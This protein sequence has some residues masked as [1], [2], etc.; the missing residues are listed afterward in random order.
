MS[1]TIQINN[2]GTLT[3]PIGI[4]KRLGL[5]K[6]GAV[7]AEETEQGI[8][9]KPA[10]TYPIEI[11]SEMRVKEFDDQDSALSAYMKKKTKKS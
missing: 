9:I 8:V 4:R 7:I 11:Y 6:G 2:R 5:E 1:T 10:V 3:L